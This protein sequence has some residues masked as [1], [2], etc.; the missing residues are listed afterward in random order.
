MRTSPN[1]QKKV[2]TSMACTWMVPVGTEKT[3]WLMTNSLVFFTTEFHV[4][5]SRP[6]WTSRSTPISTLL[7]FTRPQRE[8]VLFQQL[9]NPPTSLL[10]S[11]SPLRLV[12]TCG[13][14]EPLPCFAISTSELKA[15][16]MRSYASFAFIYAVDTEPSSH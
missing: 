2:C 15:F 14:A 3:R 9:V 13:F 11:S 10:E 16:L 4:F 6:R 8:R 1:H 5:T 7:H 12:L